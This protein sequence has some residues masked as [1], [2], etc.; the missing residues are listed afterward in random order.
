MSFM[1]QMGKPTAAQLQDRI[2]N[3]R[4]RLH[5]EGRQLLLPLVLRGAAVNI[6]NP[7]L[8]APHKFSAILRI[9]KSCRYID[10]HQCYSKKWE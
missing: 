4:S 10:I 7:T 9:Y 5:L 3:H 8:P 2:V 6:P 1:L